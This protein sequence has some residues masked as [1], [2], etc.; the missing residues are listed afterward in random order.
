VLAE[1]WSSRRAN[2]HG[3]GAC[4]WRRKRGC[5]RGTCGSCAGAFGPSGKIIEA[6]LPVGHGRPH[7]C[8]RCGTQVVRKSPFEGVAAL[9]ARCRSARDPAA[10]RFILNPSSQLTN[11]FQFNPAACRWAIGSVAH[12]TL[13]PDAPSSNRLSHALR[14]GRRMPVRQFH[15]RQPGPCSP[16]R[17]RWQV[18]RGET[19]ARSIGC[20][21][22]SGAPPACQGVA[23]QPS[24]SL[25]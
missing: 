4:Q 12:R 5:A 7:R 16:D 19:S 22:G 20:G 24:P 6:L 11:R 2:V 10:A 23:H 1:S 8:V 15:A 14:A 9:P 3:R 25:S 21:A 17:R 18:C 13:R